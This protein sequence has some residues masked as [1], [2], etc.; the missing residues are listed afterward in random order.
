MGELTNLICQEWDG[1]N[2]DYNKVIC[3][4]TYNLGI[5]LRLDSSKAR[6]VLGWKPKWDIH[7]SVK[8]MVKLYKDYL[9]NEDTRTLIYRNIEEWESK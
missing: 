8:N 9:K 1:I 7:K 6:R 2:K 4:V 3:P 5:D